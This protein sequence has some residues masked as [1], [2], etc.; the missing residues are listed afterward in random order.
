MLKCCAKLC[1]HFY[2]LENNCHMQYIYARRYF[3]ISRIDC[4]VTSQVLQWH[5][6][7]WGCGP[8]VPNYN[9][10]QWHIQHWGC[11][12]TVPNYNSLQWHIQHWGCGPLLTNC[13]SNLINFW[14]KKCLAHNIMSVICNWK[15]LATMKLLTTSNYNILEW[16]K[17]HNS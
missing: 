14:R 9:S 1:I 11:G 12:P 17:M 16:L 8:P 10:L 7:H 3:S 5:I 13:N 2:W 15:S 6:Q 4:C